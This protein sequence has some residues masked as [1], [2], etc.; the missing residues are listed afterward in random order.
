MV[1]VLALTCAQGPDTRRHEQYTPWAR[2]A[3]MRGGERHALRYHGRR[4]GRPGR[5]RKASIRRAR[6]LHHTERVMI[7][8]DVR[9]LAQVAPTLLCAAAAAD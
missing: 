1:L 9:S 8:L 2:A 3:A 7:T 5:R 4:G 6:S